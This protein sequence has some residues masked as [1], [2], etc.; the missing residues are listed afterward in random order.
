MTKRFV[1]INEDGTGGG[2]PGGTGSRDDMAARNRDGSIWIVPRATAGDPTTFQRVAEL[3]GRTE[4]GR[5]NIPT[6]GP[7]SGRPA[8]SSTLSGR[9]GAT[10]SCSTSR[11]TPRP[12]LRGGRPSRTGSCCSCAAKAEVERAA[13]DKSKRP[14]KG[15]GRKEP[16]R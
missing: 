3:V 14:G 7:A 1:A 9:S 16:G 10:R 2:A 5:D 11:R 13:V 4:G 15:K 12:R 8:G 6:V